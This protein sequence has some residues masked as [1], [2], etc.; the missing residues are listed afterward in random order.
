MFSAPILVA[1][2]GGIANASFYG[3]SALYATGIGLPVESV[4]FF[5]AFVL[6]APAVS[7]IPLGAL[8]DRFTRMSVASACALAAVAACSVLIVIETPSLWLAC[9]CGGIVGASM[10]PMYAFGLSRIVD[11]SPDAAQIEATSTGLFAYNAGAFVG[12]VLAGSAMAVFG[13]IGLYVFLV[14]VATV[15]ALSAFS[16]MGFAKCCPERLAS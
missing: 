13:P 16:D 1:L 2:C 4:A 10:V 14:I 11:A 6:V 8:A 9:I 7:E 5:V 15:A 3:L 12:P